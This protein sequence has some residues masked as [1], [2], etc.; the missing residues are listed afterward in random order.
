MQ[1]VTGFIAQVEDEII[2]SCIID[3][4]IFCTYVKNIYIQN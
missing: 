3:P 1:V 4:I 2:F